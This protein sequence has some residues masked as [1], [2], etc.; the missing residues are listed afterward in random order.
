MKRCQICGEPSGIYEVCR[1]CKKLIE[2]G[3][4]SI[5][6]R[7]GQYYET[8]KGCD[9]K[10]NE[11]IPTQENKTTII[12]NTTTAPSSEKNNQEESSFSKGCGP[13]FGIGCGCLSF[14]I[15]VIVVIAIVIS[16]A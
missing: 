6:H 11:P 12:N 4:V 9:C 8:E 15:F 16:A 5:C 10:T 1:N 2:S 13:T 3:E 7:C 14:F